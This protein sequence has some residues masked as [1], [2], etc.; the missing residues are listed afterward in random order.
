RYAG[1]AA[2]R[3]RRLPAVARAGAAVAVQIAGRVRLL[4]PAPR[5][6]APPPAGGDGVADTAG[7]APWISD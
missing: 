3:P 5:P 7:S 2:P 4:R 6:P 1:R